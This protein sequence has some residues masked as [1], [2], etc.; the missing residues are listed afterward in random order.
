MSPTAVLHAEWIKIRSLRASL[1]S[2]LALA[3]VTLVI[4]ALVL[5]SLDPTDGSP[6]HDDPLLRAF[7]ALNFAQ[8]AALAFG[9]TAMSCEYAH[10]ALR[11]SLTAVPR[12]DLFYLAKAAVIGAAALLVGVVTV[13]G[14]FFLGQAL[15]GEHGIGIGDPGALRACLGGAVGLA[16]TALLATGVT[17]L[18]R[19][20]IATLSILI[21]LFLILSFVVG[22]TAGG[23]AEFLP[24]RAGRQILHT[25]PEG[26]LGPWSGL[27]VLAL[28]A[29][30]A[31]C[32]GWWSLRRRD[33]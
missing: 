9:T 15:L 24:D 20:G 18:L 1:G 33:A 19:S 11:L 21:P 8:V 4:T 16:L 22:D 10:H 32:A 27:G 12:R 14:S 13:F 29:L 6:V 28:W 7:Y 3:V 2:L 30:A 5:G 26:A 17:T 25:D 23:A 31:L